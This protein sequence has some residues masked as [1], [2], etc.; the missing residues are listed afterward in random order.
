[1]G[2]YEDLEQEAVP[3]HIQQ[4]R[5]LGGSQTKEGRSFRSQFMRAGR[6]EGEQQRQNAERYAGLE[7]EAAAP[8]KYLEQE[9]ILSNRPEAPGWVRNVGNSIAKAYLGTGAAAVGNVKAM[10]NMTSEL[11]NGVMF[12]ATGDGT[13]LQGAEDNYQK[14]DEAFDPYKENIQAASERFPTDMSTA[15][16]WAGAVLG[17]AVGYFSQAIAGGHLLGPAG[18]AMVG[19]NA[20]GDQAAEKAKA[21]GASTVEQETERMLVGTITAITELIQVPRLLKFGKKSGQTMEGFVQAARDRAWKQMVKE[22]KK[23]TGVVVRS[24]VENAIEEFVQEGASI[25]VPY[26]NRKDAPRKA[27]GTI[28]LWAIGEQLGEAAAAGALAG[29]VLAGA[30][31]I[32][33]FLAGNKGAKVAEPAAVEPEVNAEEQLKS[34]L[35]SLDP[36]T[37]ATQEQLNAGHDMPEMLGMSK[38]DRRAFMKEFTGLE[39][40]KEMNTV[41]AQV[42]LDALY[43]RAD[44]EGYVLDMH[45]SQRIF[46][47]NVSINVLTPAI[48]KSRVLGVNFI[49][50]PAIMGKRAHKV[51]FEKI[52]GQLD[53]MHRAINKLGNETI[54]SKSESVL[55]NRPTKSVVKWAEIMDTHE[56]APEWMSKDELQVF[57]YFRTLSQGLFVRQNEVR[58]R[59]GMDPIDYRKGYLRHIAEQTADDIMQK[60]MAMPPEIAHVFKDQAPS[61]VFNAMAKNRIANA[62][63]AHYSRDLIAVSR[64][65]TWTALKEI[66]L[67]EPLKFFREQMGLHAQHIPDSTYKWA[68][69]FVKQSILGQQTEVDTT[70]DEYVRKSGIGRLMERTL[71]NFGR[72]IGRRPLT[73]LYGKLGTANIHAVLGWRPRLIIR[74]KFQLVQNLALYGPKS[75]MRAYLGDDANLKEIMTDNLYVEAYRGFEALDGFSMKRL[76][77]LNMK[78]F[79]WSAFTNMHRTMKVAYYDAKDLVTNP[80]YADLGWADPQRD[81]T[82]PKDFLYPSE[83]ELIAKEM[84]LGASTTQYDYMAMA[85]PELFRNKTAIPITR[86]QSWWMNHFFNFHR[87]ALNRF[88]KGETADGNKLPLSRRVNYLKYLTLGGFILNTLGYGTS[89][90][91]GAAPT[92][93]PPMFTLMLS[94]YHAA[95]EDDES[96]RKR[97]MTLVWSSL[98]TFIPGYL[99]AKDWA[100]FI[101]S[102]GDWTQLVFYNKGIW[103]SD[104]EDTGGKR[105]GTKQEREKK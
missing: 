82:E 66:H 65:M 30:G 27:D 61:Q 59:L 1:M 31:G 50:D 58:E 88:L 94:M 90:L 29:G 105:D 40:M 49:L 51:E 62:L 84:V 70:L 75:I 102:K 45:P 16:N 2:F 33:S 25:L 60:T 7:A 69:K 20:A 77:K 41:Q 99:T 3:D 100:K 4:Y 81:Y 53:G 15:A 19:F 87:E 78:P 28:D 48:V 52:N 63:E 13:Y 104:A 91:F 67:N 39:S 85:M 46:R 10:A 37:L 34:W 47:S 97:A 42:F 5:S 79:Q 17:Q 74:N 38:A 54:R 21:A 24:S 12:Q 101:A 43:K 73:S 8:Y 64:A 26:A 36:D 55:H 96:K 103:A 89:F 93:T 57:D 95:V 80:K 23:F 14:L 32:P 92:A 56:E 18:V 86:L 22:G 35:A 72:S 6:L 9:A 11:Y 98:K 68:Q 76:G 71:Q 44:E 83:K